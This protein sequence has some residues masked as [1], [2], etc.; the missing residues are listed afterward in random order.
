MLLYS[1][2]WLGSTVNRGGITAP[3]FFNVILYTR[4]VNDDVLTKLPQIPGFCCRN[5]ALYYLANRSKR[6]YL[7]LFF[8]APYCILVL[9]T[10]YLLDG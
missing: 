1:N 2:G 7:F 4:R 3:V 8:L 10:F 6:S 9:C 5:V